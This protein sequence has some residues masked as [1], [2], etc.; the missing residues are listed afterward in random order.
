MTGGPDE[1]REYRCV[2]ARPSANMR[3]ALALSRTQG[4][5]KP[6][7]Q[8]GATIVDS[9]QRVQR[10]ERVLVDKRRI[11]TRQRSQAAEGRSDG[12][13]RLAEKKLAR[14]SGV[15]GF[16]GRIGD[17]D[18]REHLSG[19]GAADDRELGWSEGGPAL[20]GPGMFWGDFWHIGKGLS[21][22]RSGRPHM[23]G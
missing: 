15:S 6:G 7:V 4:I 21:V 16:E 23:K 18:N 8:R 3:D 1:F 5:E 13:W 10:E 12:P 22:G 17:A 9:A 20:L 11:G 14:H 2:I 19:V